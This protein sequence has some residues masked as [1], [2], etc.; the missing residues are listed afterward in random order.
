MLRAEIE[1]KVLA[2]T[3][4]NSMKIRV[5]SGSTAAAWLYKETAV[6]NVEVDPK[7]WQY[8]LMDVITTERHIQQ[9]RKFLQQ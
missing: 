1:K 6:T 2:A 3:G 9:F 4:R 5:R 7:D 8:L